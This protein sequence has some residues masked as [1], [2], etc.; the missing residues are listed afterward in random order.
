MSKND[1]VIQDTHVFRAALLQ[2][3]RLF[4]ETFKVEEGFLQRMLGVY[5]HM[6]LKKLWRYAYGSS[7]A[8]F[9]GFLQICLHLHKL[10]LQGDA[11]Q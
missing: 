1:T 7:G 4:K 3:G 6:F 8:L 11:M 2:I 9:I 10:C 5:I